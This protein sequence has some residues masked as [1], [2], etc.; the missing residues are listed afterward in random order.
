MANF[1]IDI[2]GVITANP[3]ALSWLTYHLC[4]NENQNKVYI[5]SWRNGTDKDRTRETIED[6]RRFNI[7]YHQII[8]APAKY[9]ARV[10][11]YWK[12]NKLREL[13]IDIWLDDEIKIYTRD[14]KIPLDLL[15]PNVLK[16]WI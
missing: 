5:I 3:A 9:S 11:A 6:L 10:A 15:L 13:K 16:I 2:D 14:F 8:M 1:A 7:T 12:I 4:K